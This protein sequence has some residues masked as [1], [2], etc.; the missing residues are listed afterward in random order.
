MKAEGGRKDRRGLRISFILHPSSF[1]LGC[2]RAAAALAQ[3]FPTKPV[4]VINPAAP[5]GNSD[6]FL[7]IASAGIQQ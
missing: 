7:V 1:I 6:I 2:A 5:G 4:R 3:P